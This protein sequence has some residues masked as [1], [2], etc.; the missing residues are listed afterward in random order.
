MQVMN[1]MDVIKHIKEVA[2]RTIPANGHVLL[3]GSRARNEA[4]EDS[5][6][7]LLILLDKSR[8]EKKD[9]DNVAFPFTSLGWDIGEMI[10]PVIY[11]QEEWKSCQCLP[12]YKN[13]ENDKIVLK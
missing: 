9:Y 13:V 6:W 10:I 11:T 12:F 3:Y 8:I 4:H 2:E 1:R 5:D 7:D